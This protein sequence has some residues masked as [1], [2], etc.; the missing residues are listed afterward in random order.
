MRALTFGAMAALL[1]AGPALADGPIATAPASGPTA[2]EPTTPVGALPPTAAAVSPDPQPM[3]M[4][5]CG[6]EK[7]KPDGALDTAP[8]G[9]VEASV[10][11][12]G[13]RRIA[14]AVCQP[15][16]QD[17]YVAISISDAQGG[18]RRR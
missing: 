7:I 13:Y 16:G 1:L 15:I 11:T 8:H 3:A 10:G 5:P 12:N 14:G 2:P 4:G 9:E 18:G 17:G 6:P